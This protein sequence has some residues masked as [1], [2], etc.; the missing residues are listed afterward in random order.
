MSPFAMFKARSRF[1]A[2]KTYDLD[3]L[4]RAQPAILESEP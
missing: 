4:R 3:N 1:S 2:H